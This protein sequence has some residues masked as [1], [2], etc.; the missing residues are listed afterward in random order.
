[1][2]GLFVNKEANKMADKLK[3]NKYFRC[4]AWGVLICVTILMPICWQLKDILQL[5]MKH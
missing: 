5:V 1:M 4:F 2:F 3:E